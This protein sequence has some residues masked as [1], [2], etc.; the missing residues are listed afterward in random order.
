MHK[1]IKIPHVPGAPSG[2]STI[3]E[4]MLKKTKK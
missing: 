4:L 1:P 2:R 3:G